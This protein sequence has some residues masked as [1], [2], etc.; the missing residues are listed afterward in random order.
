[1]SG[2]GQFFVASNA[3]EVRQPSLNRWPRVELA[4]P[5]LLNTSHRGSSSSFSPSY[6]LL[7][8]HL[9]SRHT[10]RHRH[11]PLWSRALEASPAP[12]AVSP[13]HAALPLSSSTATTHEDKEATAIS[14]T[15]TPPICSG[16]APK[17]NRL[18]SPLRPCSKLAPSLLFLPSHRQ[19]PADNTAKLSSTIL[20]RGGITFADRV[21]PS[22]PLCVQSAERKMSSN[23]KDKDNRRRRRSSSL[24]YQEP[25]ESLE[26]QSDQAVLPNLNAQWVNA[27]G[28]LSARKSM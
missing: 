6:I 12:A 1:M 21:N 26:Q 3:A 8:H 9:P 23:S 14:S 18:A 24:M 5:G 17:L 4:P 11:S 7:P 20:Q 16:A 22:P 15:R 27:K 13:N 25:P 19:R 10:V 28:E 2:S